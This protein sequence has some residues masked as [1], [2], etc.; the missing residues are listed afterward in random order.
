MCGNDCRR[1]ENWDSFFEQFAPLWPKSTFHNGKAF[2]AV[3]TLTHRV[4]YRKLFN[5]KSFWMSC[6]GFGWSYCICPTG[7]Y[8]W[9]HSQIEQIYFLLCQCVAKD[10][11]YFM[12][13]L[14]PFHPNLLNPLWIC[15][16]HTIY[17][18][19]HSKKKEVGLIQIF[20]AATNGQKHLYKNAQ[21][22]CCIF[23]GD[24]RNNLYVY[25]TYI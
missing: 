1:R 13:L 14:H 4:R 16:C 3:C 9:S 12:P 22:N 24:Y 19:I 18:F 5:R 21:I 2:V 10:S 11:L 7:I 17:T 15:S 23:M 25:I 6:R 8:D 20:M